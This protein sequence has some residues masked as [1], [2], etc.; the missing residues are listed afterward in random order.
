MSSQRPRAFSLVEL[1]VVIGV[2]GILIAIVAPALRGAR[3]AVGE[4]AS[5][6]NLCGIGKTFEA[7]LSSANEAYPRVPDGEFIPWNAP[8]ATGGMTISGTPWMSEHVWPHLIARVAPWQEH[9]QSWFSPGVDIEEA[10]RDGG[11]VPSYFYC[12]SFVAAPA[13][14]TTE[15]AAQAPQSPGRFLVAVRS[16]QVAH[17]GAKV[18]LY[19]HAVAYVRRADKPRYLGL[20]DLPTPMLFA[21]SH[22]AA[23]VPR[24]AATPYRNVLNAERFNDAPLYNTPEGVLGPDY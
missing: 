10:T 18:M 12:H 11:F 23:H 5:L 20:P 3:K 22:A 6:A 16:V 1:L 9:L 21:D 15:G 4:A 17:P 2:I 13:L 24:H 7:Y 8:G 19:D 14:W